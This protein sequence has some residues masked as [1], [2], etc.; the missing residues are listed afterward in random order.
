[1]RIANTKLTDKA[2][3]STYCRLLIGSWSW[4]IRQDGGT[5]TRADHKTAAPALLAAP[6]WRLGSVSGRESGGAWRRNAVLQNLI[7]SIVRPARV[8]LPALVVL[9]QFL[10]T[11]LT[12]ATPA[13][14]API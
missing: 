10:P 2:R 11:G 7:R 5:T 14:A 9:T 6:S 13:R 8:M 12:P 1:M 3:K 4:P